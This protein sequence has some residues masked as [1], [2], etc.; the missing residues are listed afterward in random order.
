MQELDRDLS[1]SHVL[2]MNQLLGRETL[3]ASFNATLILGFAVLSLLLS[4][5][6]IFGV[7]SYVI[8]QRTSE[9]GIRMALGAQRQQILTSVLIDGLRPAFAGLVFGLAASAATVRLIRS[10]LFA[11]QPLDP[12]V[13]VLV[14]L[15]LIVVSGVA[16]MAP[17][18]RASRLDPMQALRTE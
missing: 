17:A 10:M 8:A 12:V 14:S 2:T 18:W 4:A 13:F 7:V 9:F 1:V 15:G 5:V 3:D 16:C 6:G 11:T